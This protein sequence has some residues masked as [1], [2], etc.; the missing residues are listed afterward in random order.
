MERLFD[1]I[2]V[3]FAKPRT[4]RLIDTRKTERNAEAIINMAVMRRGVETS[5]YTTVPAGKFKDGD[6]YRG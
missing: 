2:E 5:F 3:R 6:K 1:V 4:V